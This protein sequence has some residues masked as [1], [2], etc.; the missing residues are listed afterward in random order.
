MKT[1]LIV[2]LLM[3]ASCGAPKKET[4]PEAFTLAKFIAPLALKHTGLWLALSNYQQGVLTRL[5]LPS[6][7]FSER[8]PLKYDSKLVSLESNSFYVLSRMGEDSLAYFVGNE[9]RPSAHQALPITDYNAIALARDEQGQV[10][11]AGNDSNEIL[12]LSADL[13]IPCGRVSLAALAESVDGLAEPS[14]MIFLPPKTL[15][16]ATQRVD[17][18][19]N[20]APAAES[21]LAIIDTVSV[22]LSSWQKSAVSNPIALSVDPQGELLLTGAGD[23]S[24][25]QALSGSQQK[26]AWD[27][28]K[29]SA[30]KWEENKEARF[31]SAATLGSGKKVLLAWYPEAKKSCVEVESIQLYCESD[32]DKGF[33]FTQLVADGEAIFVSYAREAALLILNAQ[34]AEKNKI[35]LPMPAISMSFGP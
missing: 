32:A 13:K 20:W 12:C 9:T 35:T 18:N 22:Q 15:V 28:Q 3:L 30:K 2:F 14:A 26:L 5:D 25:T 10:W 34:T 21:A 6:A 16:V 29:I 17:R 7:T 19:N 33:L 31:L 23:L 11:L 1:S 27:G 24:L 8:G 4:P